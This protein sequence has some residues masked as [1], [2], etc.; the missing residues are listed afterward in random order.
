MD[1]WL[2]WKPTPHKEREEE[3]DDRKRPNDINDPPGSE[4][5]G[6]RV[7]KPIT[8]IPQRGNPDLVRTLDDTR[9]KDPYFRGG[10]SFFTKVET[11]ESETGRGSNRI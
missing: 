3:A 11:E 1:W 8:P 9:T 7:I 4:R 2:T 5:S 10:S 6:R